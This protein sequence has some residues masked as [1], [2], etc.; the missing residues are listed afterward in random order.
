[1]SIYFDTP[2]RTLA[3]SGLTLRRRVEGDDGRWQLKLP[4]GAAR[5]ELE[6]EGGP[7]PPADLRA[8]L[9]AHRALGELEPVAELLTRRS[10]VRVLDGDRPLAEAVLDEVEAVDRN[11]SSSGFRELE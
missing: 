9:R 4:A 11:G 7:L 3:R 5:R 8:L 1:T 6:F 2:Q 10:G